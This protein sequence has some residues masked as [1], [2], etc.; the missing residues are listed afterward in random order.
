MIDEP[1]AI[2]VNINGLTTSH[3]NLTRTMAPAYAEG[4][5]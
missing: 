1:R 2:Q 3:L 4:R 5:P